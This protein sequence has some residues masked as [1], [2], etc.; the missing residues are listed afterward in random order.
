MGHRV[1]RRELRAK[2]NKK[3]LVTNQKIISIWPWVIPRVLNQDAVLQ[4]NLILRD[5]L[6]F[7]SSG[8]EP[9]THNEIPDP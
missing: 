1:W 3:L 6:I 2:Y 4:I 9:G 7:I 5:G 8:I